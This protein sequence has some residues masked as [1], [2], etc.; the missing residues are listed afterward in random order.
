[1]KPKELIKI[2]K[3]L[4]Q[5][6]DF[7][8][9]TLVGFKGK[10]IDIRI[11]EITIRNDNREIYFSHETIKL[12]E[13][14]KKLDN[15]PTIVDI[16][17]SFIQYK[18]LSLKDKYH[19]YLRSERWRNKREIVLKKCNYICQSCFDN[20]ATEVHHLTYDYL[21]FDPIF[22]LTPLCF[23][24]H[25]FITTF[26]EQNPK[27]E[28]SYGSIYGGFADYLIVEKRMFDTYLQLFNSVKD[29]KTIKEY[30]TSLGD[31][32]VLTLQSGEIKNDD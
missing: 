19:I 20:D 7:T 26:D 23:E 5:N 16:Q 3:K 17:E 24:C 30:G 27:Y 25:M 8:I 31:A 9:H 13:Y 21:G 28:K 6:E 4:D 11:N 10:L 29:F 1:M 22:I 32:T 2:F 14:S 12:P 15:P 18:K